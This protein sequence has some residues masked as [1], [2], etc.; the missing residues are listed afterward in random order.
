M[1]IRFRAAVAA[2]ASGASLGLAAQS[3]AAQP[4]AAAGPRAFVVWVYSHYPYS[5]GRGKWSFTQPGVFD[6]LM[7]AE[8]RKDVRLSK[9][10][11]GAVDGDPLCLCQDDAGLKPIIGEAKMTGPAAATVPV[12]LTY[13]GQGPAASDRIQ[14]LL[15]IEHGQWRIA[16]VRAADPKSFRQWLIKANRDHA[17]GRW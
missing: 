8:F 9:G 17:A 4:A 2:L 5:P 12:T 10:E 1:K 6:D 11:V 7:V 15:V 16:D 3:A 14:L 13:P